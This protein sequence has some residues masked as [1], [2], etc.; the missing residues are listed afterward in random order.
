MHMRRMR[1]RIENMGLG[2]LCSVTLLY[3]VNPSQFFFI[4]TVF[5]V[6]DLYVPALGPDTS[7]VSLV[8]VTHTVL[9]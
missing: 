8:Q 5:L 4:N 6:A 9:V 2:L 1:I 3:T 7:K